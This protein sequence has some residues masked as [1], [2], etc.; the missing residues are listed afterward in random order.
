MVGHLRQLPPVAAPY[1]FKPPRHIP[2]GECVGNHL[3]QKF[4]LFELVEIM[5]QRGEYD[6]CKALNNMSQG[7]MDADDIRLIRSRKITPANCPPTNAIHLFAT[8][9]ECQEH[10][11]MIHIRLQSEPAAERALS[12]AF[13]KVQGDNDVSYH[14][15][16]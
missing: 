11:T 2:L 8:N 15:S 5:R 14:N 7:C 6:F 10:N 9:K 16:V 12:T 13:D 1:V 4:Q 3:W